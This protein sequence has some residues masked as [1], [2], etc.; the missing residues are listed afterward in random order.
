MA[1]VTLA[2]PEPGAST[3]RPVRQAAGRSASPLVI[4]VFVALPVA[5]AQPR[6]GVNDV[7]RSWLPLSPLVRV[8]GVGDLRGRPEHRG[9]LCAGL[10][11]LGYVAFWAIGGYTG[12]WLLMSDLV[13]LGLNIHFFDAVPSQDAGHPHQLLAG[14]LDR[15]RVLRR[16]RLDHR[17]ADAAA[18]ERLP[19]PG[20]A[21]A[22]ARSSLSSS[23]TATISAA[24]TPAATSGT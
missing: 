2:P 18:Q 7:R 21:R 10:L 1:A 16:L 23:A 13:Q 8:P 12:G 4:V 11:D 9:R 6:E 22:S 20:D 19:R 17:R 3:G 15:R 24:S 5:A 14:A